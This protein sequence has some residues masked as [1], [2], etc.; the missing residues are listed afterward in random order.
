MFRG[1]TH[2]G[3]TVAY[4]FRGREVRSEELDQIQNLLAHDS[5]ITRRKL[6]QELC[7]AWGWLQPNGVLCDVK[8]RSL[9][10]AMHRDGLIELPE[11]RWRARRPAHRVKPVTL[12]LLDMSAVECS[13]AQ[14]GPLEL[15]PVRRTCEEPLVQSLIATH[16]YLGYTRP[17]GEHL[18]YLVTAQDRPIACFL[19]SSSP[20]HLAPRDTHIGWKPAA[21]RA[22]IH[23]VAYQS[24]FLILP[25]VRVPHLAS[26][27]LGQMNRR[28]SGDWEQSYA[29]PI[30]FVET[31]VDPTRYRGTC[32]R[33]GNWTF[34]GLTTGRGKNDS[35]HRPNRTLKEVYGYALHKKFR[36]LLC[37]PGGCE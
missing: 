37:A 23:Q 6:S 24:R 19:W 3:V 4:R 26:H 21:R 15:R 5:K 8:C 34:L 10:L 1:G 33:A 17:V 30:Y 18:K 36:E 11:P 32:Y 35:T 29:H 13:L 22:H 16:H 7:R 14:L 9:L 31:F 27:L 2:N 25:W 12:P 20:R 28:L